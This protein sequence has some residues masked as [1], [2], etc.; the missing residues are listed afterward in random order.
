MT[1]GDQP[2]NIDMD[3]P[4]TLPSRRVGFVSAA[5]VEENSKVKRSTFLVRMPLLFSRGILMKR[6]ATI[7]LPRH[8]NIAFLPHTS[9]THDKITDHELV[10]IDDMG[11][12][13]YIFDQRTTTRNRGRN[14]EYKLLECK[15]QVESPISLYQI[16][17]A[18]EVM[19]LL[20][21]HDI[22][23]TAK[24]YC[25]AVNTKAIGL[26]M[27]LDAKRSAKNKIID[28]FIDTIEEDISCKVF[29]DLVPH[30]GL[31]RLGKK[32][33]YGQ[34]LKVMVDVKY[35]T[36]TAKLIQEGLK[37][38]AFGIGMTDVRLMPV[39]PIPNLMTPEMFGKMIIAHN[40]S[41]YGIAEIQ[42]DNVW[43][44]DTI[45]V[46]PDKI[47]K[48]FNLPYDVEDKDDKYSLRDLIMPIF[49][50]HF[51]NKPV[52]RDVYIMRGRLMIVCE[53][54]KIAET[55]KLVDMLLQYLKDEYDVE[56][57]EL[58]HNEDKFAEW[59]GCSTPKNKNR[60]P[61]RSGTLIF[62]EGGLLKA[63]VNSFL[64]EHLDN[65]P[66]GLVP[67]AGAQAK[68]PDLS[69]PPPVSLV[70][71]GRTRPIV[72][73]M[74]FTSTAVNAWASAKTWASITKTK[75]E[76]PKQK[77]PVKQRRLLPQN[78]V[79]EMD[80]VT[81]STMSMTSATQAALDAMRNSIL[82]LQSDKKENEAKIAL[83][84]ENIAKIARDVTTLAESQKNTNRDF[85]HIKEQMVNMS[86]ESSDMKQDMMEMKSMIMSIA[87]HLGGVR[88]DDAPKAPYDDRQLDTQPQ[89]Q[90]QQHSMNINQTQSNAS[91]TMSDIVTA[92]SYDDISSTID[93]D[94]RKKL[95]HTHLQVFDIQ[96]NTPTTTP[97]RANHPPLAQQTLVSSNGSD[98]TL[99]MSE[100]EIASMSD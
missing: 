49:W 48:R 70:P 71:R 99:S 33:I 85:L 54:S 86:K 91:H 38:G 73:P 62:G 36:V 4:T 9:S 96:A 10:P 18:N 65:L 27:N 29:I 35:A 66:S 82:T 7:L 88:T 72:D 16:K 89:S 100:E 55:T 81:H 23:I 47:K 50:G 22:Y 30:R 95:K 58:Y 90:S 15:I 94:G 24:S 8:K 67:P 5:T 34:F 69:R 40:D 12:S 37:K 77:T 98:K 28:N 51:K 20:K 25:P 45:S 64:D 74:E 46:V 76:K 43:D 59:V 60:H 39:Y 42:V 52:V 14:N 2:F 79:V 26:L 53:K 44:I 6:L 80:T 57:D 83:L 87:T 1:T 68:K 61:A 92:G 93:D 11:I 19:E 75:K 31:V 63:T 3:L 84:D 41:M 32:V 78:E 97:I 17:G 21:K 13:H 56:S